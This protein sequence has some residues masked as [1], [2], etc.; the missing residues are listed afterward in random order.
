MYTFKY[1]SRKIVN[2]YS[3]KNT[4]LMIKKN[5][6]NHLSLDNGKDEN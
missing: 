2:V 4:I 1:I 6:K 3:I 5:Y